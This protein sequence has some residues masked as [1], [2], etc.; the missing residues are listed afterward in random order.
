M[1]TKLDRD[2]PT[3]ELE[4]TAVKRELDQVRRLGTNRYGVFSRV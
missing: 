3:G 1:N 2:E 4:T